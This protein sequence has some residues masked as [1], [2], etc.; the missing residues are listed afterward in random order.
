MYC[1]FWIILEIIKITLDK[2]SKD[3]GR[4]KLECCFPLPFLREKKT[5]GTSWERRN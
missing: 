5:K 4:W 1:E 3:E 2:T